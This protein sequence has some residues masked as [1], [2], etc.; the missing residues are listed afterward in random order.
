[1]ARCGS[2]G[3]S[4]IYLGLVSMHYALQKKIFHSLSIT[5]I[6]G[7][8]HEVVNIGKKITNYTV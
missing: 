4:P 8:I 3:T 1:M 2:K 6:F 7:P 5:S